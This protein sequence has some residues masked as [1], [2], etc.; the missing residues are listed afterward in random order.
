MKFL[1]G[2]MGRYASQANCNPLLWMLALAVFVLGVAYHFRDAILNVIKDTVMIMAAVLLAYGIA[3]VTGH[4]I[5]HRRRL[6]HLH[7][8]ERGTDVPEKSAT[9]DPVEE[10]ERLVSQAYQG[11]DYRA[12]QGR[13]RRVR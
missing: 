8:A 10:A 13:S 7:E 11:L 2:K 4:I 9:A 3:H 1:V 6:A 5:V 12:T